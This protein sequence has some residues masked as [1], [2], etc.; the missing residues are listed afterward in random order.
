MHQLAV[1]YR[2][3]LSTT[4]WSGANPISPLANRHHL[5][6][7]VGATIFKKALGSVISNR[8]GTKFGRIV[9]HVNMH[10][11]TESDFWCITLYFQDGVHEVISCRKVLPSGECWRSIWPAHMQQHL[12]LCILHLYSSDISDDNMNTWT[13]IVIKTERKQVLIVYYCCYRRLSTNFLPR[14]FCR[15]CFVW[16]DCVFCVA[17]KLVLE[18][19]RIAGLSRLTGQHVS[20]GLSAAPGRDR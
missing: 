13:R 19:P 12:Y 8:I 20:P 15:D 9:L 17:Y 6:L 5:I 11:L 18:C 4:F 16:W 1:C 3:R 14:Y 10:R 2:E 7:L